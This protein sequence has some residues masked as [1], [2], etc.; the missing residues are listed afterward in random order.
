MREIINMHTIPKTLIIATDFIAGCSAKNRTPVPIIVVAADNRIAVLYELNDSFLYLYL[1][2]KPS[3][4]KILKSS[5][6]PKIKV[7]I[8]MLTKL[9]LILVK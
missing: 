9:N 5:P 4:I 3:V 1:A 6:N 2:N 7:D 8:T